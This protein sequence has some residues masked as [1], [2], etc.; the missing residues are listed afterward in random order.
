MWSLETSK[1]QGKPHLEKFDVPSLVVLGTGDTGV[2][3]GD[4]HAIHGFIGASEKRLE[5]LPGAH[6]FEGPAEHRENV[7]DLMAAWIDE[8][9]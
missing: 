1:C 2:F 6:Y 8:R 4:A 9:T 7:A 5:L 3:P